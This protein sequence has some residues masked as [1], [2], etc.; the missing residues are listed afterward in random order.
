MKKIIIIITGITL[1][2][3]PVAYAQA[4]GDDFYEVEKILNIVLCGTVIILSA[5][6]FL[7]FKSYRKLKAQSNEI[8]NFDEFRKTYIDANNSLIYLKDENLKYIFVNK[9]VADFYNKK[10]EDIIGHDAY[11][12]AENEYADI[13]NE[14]DL[15]VLERN[16]L[17]VNEKKWKDKRYNGWM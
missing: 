7:I 2:I 15:E 13:S 4:G 9:A 16:T 12:L 3:S 5:A 10:L 11:E 17:I 6:I 8:S 14:T 1:F